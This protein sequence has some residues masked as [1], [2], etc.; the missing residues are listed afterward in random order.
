MKSNLHIVLEMFVLLGITLR[1]LLSS[2]HH[3][4]RSLFIMA[5]DREHEEDAGCFFFSLLDKKGWHITHL[6]KGFHDASCVG[7]SHGWLVIW[8]IKQLHCILLIRFLEHEFKSHRFRLFPISVMMLLFSKLPVYSFESRV[9]VVTCGT[10]E[11]HGR[12]AICKR[13]V[14]AWIDLE[15]GYHESYRNIMFH[16]GHLFAFEV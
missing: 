9:V 2:S 13:A 16:N 12:I 15:G 1:N 3:R 5:S 8:D 7:S 11:P 6:F 14:N 4:F 10:Q